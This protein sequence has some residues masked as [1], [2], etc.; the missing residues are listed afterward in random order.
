MDNTTLHA[1]ELH[2]ASKKVGTKTLWS[3]LDLRLL[4]GEVLCVTGASGSGKSTLLNCLGLLEK[5]DTGTYVLDGKN[6]A[7]ASSRARM[8]ARRRDLGYLFQDYALVEN[9]SVAD[10]VRI[11]CRRSSLRERT[12]ASVAEALALV[13][14]GGRDKEPV[15]Q[16]SGGEQQRVAVARLLVRRPQVVLADEPTA[17]LDRANAA[18]ILGHLRAMAQDGA[19]VMIVSHDPWVAQQC[20]RR[21]DITANTP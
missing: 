16:L 1:I 3:G 2:N 20:D 17:S 10:N 7:K 6:M 9:D 19:A 4:P 21:V 13:G 18:N 5:F 8:R 15:Y 11:A 14:M 12:S